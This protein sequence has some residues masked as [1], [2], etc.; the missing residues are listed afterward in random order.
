MAVTP[1]SITDAYPLD[2]VI[3]RLDD[4]GLPVYD[5]A[6]NAETLRSVMRVLLRDGVVG[7]YGEELAVTADGSGVYVGPGC[8]IA[9]GLQAI[10]RERVKVVD[11]S[12]IAAGRYCF[13]VAAARFD[14]AYRDVQVTAS[15]TASQEYEPVRTASRYE[16]VLARVDWR[17]AV[18]DLRP[19]PK[20]CGIASPFAPLDTS[21][22]TAA[23][24]GALRNFDVRAGKT[25]TTAPGTQAAVT[26][27]KVEGEG[28]YLDMSIPRGD[29]GERGEPGRD[30]RDG[31]SGVTV[32]ANGFVTFSVEPNGDLFAETPG[33]DPASAYELDGAGNLFVTTGGA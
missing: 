18:R 28:A 12:D 7:D 14:S 2:S 4:D 26:V 33:A 5:R 11:R 25:T 6:Y 20:Y 17:G 16:I 1:K 3:E 32:P 19:D 30:G 31:A 23:L 13:V 29:R 27:R 22:F 21:T 10:L 8:L 9:D 24:D 15:V